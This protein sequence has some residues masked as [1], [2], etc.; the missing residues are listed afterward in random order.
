[1]LINFRDTLESRLD[2]GTSGKNNSWKLENV[3]DTYEF[4]NLRLGLFVRQDNF[5]VGV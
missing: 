4:M 2:I 1:M 5:S 3:L